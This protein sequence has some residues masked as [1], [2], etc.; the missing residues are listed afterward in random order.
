[1]MVFNDGNDIDI[2]KK[3]NEPIQLATVLEL[4]G[5][6]LSAIHKKEN[7]EVGNHSFPSSIISSYHHIIIIIMIITC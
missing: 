1:M 2:Y 7:D 3:V 5:S 6:V 4:Y